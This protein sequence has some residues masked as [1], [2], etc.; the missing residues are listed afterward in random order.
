MVKPKN[1]N[2]RLVS[3]TIESEKLIRKKNGKTLVYSNLRF[4]INH[5]K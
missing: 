4:D 5:I 3:E 2:K 1:D